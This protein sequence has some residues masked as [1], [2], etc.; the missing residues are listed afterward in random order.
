MES[1]KNCVRVIDG[2]TGLIV[3]WFMIHEYCTSEVTREMF[4][5]TAKVIPGWK[6]AEIP[7]D[8]FGGIPGCF[9]WR[10]PGRFVKKFHVNS[11]RV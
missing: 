11:S 7:K 1:L 8:F 9:F 5:R 4:G 3:G 2:I 10:I 6:P